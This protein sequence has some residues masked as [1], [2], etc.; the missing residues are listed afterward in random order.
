[1][2]KIIK[3]E[4]E[5]GPKAREKFELAMKAVFRVPKSEIVKT[6]K[7]YKQKRKRKKS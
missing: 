7:K 4:M 5:E 1:M 2:R 6:E 3:P